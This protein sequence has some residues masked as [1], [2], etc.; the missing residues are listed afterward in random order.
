MLVPPISWCQ[1]AN[2]NSNICPSY[3]KGWYLLLISRSVFI[4]F[5]IGEGKISGFINTLSPF[6]LILSSDHSVALAETF[7]P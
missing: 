5:L 3:I 4:A 2:H 1:L 6:A 7:L